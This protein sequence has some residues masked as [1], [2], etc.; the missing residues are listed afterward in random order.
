[1][2]TQEGGNGT[3]F[4]SRQFFRNPVKIEL[5]RIIII[6]FKFQ[7]R[8]IEHTL[9]QY[10]IELLTRQISDQSFYKPMTNNNM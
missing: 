3:Q 9:F 4:G 8:F 5:K 7:L 6:L 1:M 2:T 10:N